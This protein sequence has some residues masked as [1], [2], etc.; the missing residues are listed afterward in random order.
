M[1]VALMYVTHTTEWP[2][3]NASSSEIKQARRNDVNDARLF[4]GR[5]RRDATKITKNFCNRKARNNR[6]Y[7]ALFTM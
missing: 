2:I 5:Q 3:I 7:R 4:T 1:S 6:K